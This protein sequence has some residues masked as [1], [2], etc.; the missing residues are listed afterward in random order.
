MRATQPKNSAFVVNCASLPVISTN[1]LGVLCLRVLLLI[2][3][4]FHV[5]SHVLMCLVDAVDVLML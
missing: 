5:S 4:A 2:I 3:E 1:N